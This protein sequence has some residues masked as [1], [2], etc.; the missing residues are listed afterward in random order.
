MTANIEDVESMNVVPES[1]NEGKLN[2]TFDVHIQSDQSNT[3]TNTRA[4][5]DT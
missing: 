4:C 3:F 1:N 5:T 2:I